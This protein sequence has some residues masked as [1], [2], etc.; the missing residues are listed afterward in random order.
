MS[1]Q[2]AQLFCIKTVTKEGSIHN[3]YSIIYAIALNPRH[4]E[5]ALLEVFRG[6]H[7][8]VSKIVSTLSAVLC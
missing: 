3:M 2:K 6:P 8:N 5:I 4:F 1:E 7:C